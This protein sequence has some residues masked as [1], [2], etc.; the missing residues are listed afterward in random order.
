MIADYD[1]SVL[2]LRLLCAF[3]TVVDEGTFGRAATA[4]GYSQSSLSQQIAGARAG[5]RRPG[6]RPTGRS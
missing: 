1:H 5:G 6:V 4:F 3:E 2:E